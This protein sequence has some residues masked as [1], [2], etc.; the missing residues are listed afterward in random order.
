MPQTPCYR[1]ALIS[2]DYI[3]FVCFCETTICS[4]CNL[5]LKMGRVNC[6]ILCCSHL[7]HLSCTRKSLLGF[8]PALIHGGWKYVGGPLL[9]GLSAYSFIQLK[10]NLF[11]R[12]YC[13]YT[14][15]HK[16]SVNHL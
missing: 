7:I 3:F 2:F 15:M 10:A 14:V 16:E 13:V 4:L 9:S 6:F 1:A 5:A 11:L 12:F 8:S